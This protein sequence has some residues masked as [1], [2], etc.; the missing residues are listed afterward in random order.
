MSC[1]LWQTGMYIILLCPNRI[2]KKLYQAS[3]LLNLLSASIHN[4]CLIFI[5]QTKACQAQ[6]CSCHAHILITFI[7]TLNK[8]KNTTA[9]WKQNE[10]LCSQRKVEFFG[11]HFIQLPA[12]AW[13]LCSN[14]HS[15]HL[16]WFQRPLPT[17]MQI[18]LLLVPSSNESFDKR[19]GNVPHHRAAGVEAVLSQLT[20]YF[21]SWENEGGWEENPVIYSTPDWSTSSN[22]SH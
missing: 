14:L 1:L 8:A 10:L 13:T 20:K 9:F 21:K 16:A 4:P 2:K 15:N 22:F 7:N 18:L 11:S 3:L 6:C 12:S 19:P 5:L 17:L